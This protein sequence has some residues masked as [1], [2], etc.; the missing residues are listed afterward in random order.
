MSES[1]EIIDQALEVV[2]SEFEEA[3]MHRHPGE[4]LFFSLKNHQELLKFTFQGADAIIKKIMPHTHSFFSRLLATGGRKK[5]DVRHRSP[6][7]YFFFV[8]C[9]FLT[10]L[11]FCDS[12]LSSW[13]LE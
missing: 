5:L 11:L 3:V 6:C 1:T 4:D 7:I 8:L 12:P 10:S 2:V 9:L 13:W